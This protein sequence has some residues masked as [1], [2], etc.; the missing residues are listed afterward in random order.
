MAAALFFVSEPVNVFA[1]SSDVGLHA[2]TGWNARYK[3]KDKPSPIRYSEAPPG[4]AH[5]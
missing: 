5:K 1:G 2:D 4:S 3:D